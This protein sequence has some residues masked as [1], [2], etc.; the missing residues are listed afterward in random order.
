MEITTICKIFSPQFFSHL[1]HN[2]HSYLTQKMSSES[3]LRLIVILKSGK[4]EQQAIKSLKNLF[5]RG[6]K[7]FKLTY[8]FPTSQNELF[9]KICSVFQK[10]IFFS[11][12]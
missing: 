10:K 2:F 1:K 3:V 6:N 11:K 8:N 9:I 12:N 4:N 5:P 7:C